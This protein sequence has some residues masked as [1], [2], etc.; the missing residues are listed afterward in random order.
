MSRSRGRWMLLLMTLFFAAPLFLV[1]LMYRLDWHPAGTSRGELVTPARA[2]RVPSGL[3]DNA[4]RTVAETLFQDKWSMVYVADRCDESCMHRLHDMRQIHAS[5]AK[6]IPRVQRVLLTAEQDVADL[7]ARYP[8]L[9]VLNG[10]PLQRDE[11]RHQFELAGNSAGS[12]QRIYFVD[13]LGNLMMSYA[14]NVAAGDIRK[15]LNRLLAYA[16]AG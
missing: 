15:D 8:D 13:P 12:A 16:W 2:L 6:H 3:T 4:A 9:I 10:P 14:R 7:K 11:L 5:L 1:M